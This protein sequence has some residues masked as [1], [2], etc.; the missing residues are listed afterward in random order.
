MAGSV[1]I[2][3]AGGFGTRLR[4]AVADLP[5]CLAPVDGQPFLR[6]QLESLAARGVERFVL[7]LYHQA[8][9]VQMAVADWPLRDRIAS[10][11]ESE[12]L[13]TGGAI[14][15]A[16]RER[17]L[18]EALVA[19]GDTFLGG[20]LSAMLAPL[21]ENED[22]RLAAVNV[23]DRGRFGGIQVDAA[24]HVERFL[25]KG[26]QGPG[27]INAGFYRV[28]ASAFATQPQSSFS[29]ETA[30]LPALAQAH[31]L[32]AVEI[33]GDFIDI[34]VPEDYHRYCRDHDRLR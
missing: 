21:I 8:D 9:L 18:D 17:G 29:F 7:S 16:M 2:V 22:V 24:G 19:N 34:G 3:L 1:C 11:V 20:D 30:V 14:A 6:R 28:R 12:P 15:F 23:P 10:V 32:S 13:G 33:H 31:R 27:P 5:K 25:E 26:S 4:S